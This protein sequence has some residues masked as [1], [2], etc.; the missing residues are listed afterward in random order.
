MALCDGGTVALEMISCLVRY[1]GIR[2]FVFIFIFI[3]FWPSCLL[4]LA[5]LP[6]FGSRSQDWTSRT[7][8]DRNT[9]PSL[10]PSCMEF[11]SLVTINVQANASSSQVFHFLS[12]LYKFSSSHH[13]SFLPP[14]FFIVFITFLLPETHSFF[15][16]PPPSFLF[17]DKQASCSSPSL[18]PRRSCSALSLLLFASQALLSLITSLMGSLMG[19]GTF[20]LV[21]I[22]MF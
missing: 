8:E 19:S 6:S 16:L 14:F 5:F 20:N 12:S 11:L 7:D 13:S 21:E 1:V 17:V 10:A 9:Q 18:S 3:F 15:L 2:I 4:V 22:A